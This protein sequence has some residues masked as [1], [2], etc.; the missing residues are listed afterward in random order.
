M[1]LHFE[2]ELYERECVCAI[3]VK[4]PFGC[5]VIICGEMNKDP[6]YRYIGYRYI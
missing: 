2:V 3:K 5:T 1:S 4:Y 6:G